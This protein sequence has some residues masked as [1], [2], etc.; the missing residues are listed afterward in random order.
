MQADRTFV[1]QMS[2]SVAV[3]EAAPSVKKMRAS[4]DSLRSRI[5][6]GTDSITAAMR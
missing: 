6:R 1:S 2:W 5:A 4:D 3:G